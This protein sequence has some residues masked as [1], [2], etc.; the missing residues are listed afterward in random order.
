MKILVLRVIK[1]HII[2]I[3]LYGVIFTRCLCQKPSLARTSLVRVFIQT[4]REYNPVRRTFYDV[5]QITTIFAYRGGDDLW[6]VI[7]LHG[8]CEL[9]LL[10]FFRILT[11]DR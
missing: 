1:S 2:E 6:R 11:I 10:A 8:G 9:R 7:N 3:A 4:I 5:N